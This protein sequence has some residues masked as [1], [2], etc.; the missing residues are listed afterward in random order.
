MRGI[1]TLGLWSRAT[2]RIRD[3]LAGGS[4]EVDAA[5]REAASRLRAQA[6]ETEAEACDL[7]DELEEAPDVLNWPETLAVLREMA[8]DGAEALAAAGEAADAAYDRAP[9]PPPIDLEALVAC[10]SR[11]PPSSGR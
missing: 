10:M 8:P 6:A 9:P 2:A 7:A 4:A 3:R 5:L 11:P 1:L